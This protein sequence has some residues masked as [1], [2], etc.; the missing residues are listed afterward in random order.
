[1]EQDSSSASASFISKLNTTAKP[2]RLSATTTT[3][4][5]VTT[6]TARPIQQLIWQR[7][8]E[9]KERSVDI[10]Q[11]RQSTPKLPL[12]PPPPPPPPRRQNSSQRVEGL[13]GA[14][15]HIASSPGFYFHSDLTP[16]TE[17]EKIFSSET[18]ATLSTENSSSWSSEVNMTSSDHLGWDLDPTNPFDRTSWH[19]ARDLSANMSSLV[20]TS[21]S[22]SSDSSRSSKQSSMTPLHLDDTLSV[23]TTI[24][25]TAREKFTPLLDCPAVKVEDAGDFA[26][27]DVDEDE[28]GEGEME[29]EDEEAVASTEDR[30]QKKTDQ[31]KTDQKVTDQKSSSVTGT[32]GASSRKKGKATRNAAKEKVKAAEQPRRPSSP[33]LEYGGYKGHISRVVAMKGSGVDGEIIDDDD[34]AIADG[35]GESR[36]V[37]PFPSC[38]KHFS[39]SGHA[40][41]HSRIH[42]SLRPFQC[43]HDNCGA[44]FTRRDNCTQHQRTRHVTQLKAHRMSLEQQEKKKRSHR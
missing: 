22:D 31:K 9:A 28:D 39:T 6:S 18:S 21:E 20:P 8:L 40:R 30:D 44:I 34:D 24:S 14:N 11:G 29:I 13:V 12:F 33:L 4:I 2:I 10:L 42:A 26:V 27:V 43:P 36:H 19:K 32:G 38:E 16:L 23:S 7:R 15:I 35:I 17:P 1:M 37:C 41:R 5:N 3:T 25:D